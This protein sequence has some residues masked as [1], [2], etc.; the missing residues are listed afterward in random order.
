MPS[1]ARG[2]GAPGLELQGVVSCP[3]WA[4]G[5]KLRP[6]GRAGCIQPWSHL[7]HP[8]FALFSLC[9]VCTICVVCVSVC[10][11]AHTCRSQSRTP[12]TEFLSELEA[13]HY[14]QTGWLTGELWAVTDMPASVCGWGLALRSCSQSKCSYPLGSSLAPEAC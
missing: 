10:I 13:H 11:H 9:V 12:G 6:S 2:I 8:D 4:L 1:E 14:D 3:T 7:F 5:T